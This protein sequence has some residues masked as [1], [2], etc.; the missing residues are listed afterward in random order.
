MMISSKFDSFLF[1]QILGGIFWILFS[2]VNFIDGVGVLCFV[3]FDG[4]VW[5]SSEVCFSVVRYMCLLT[6][7]AKDLPWV[8]NDIRKF[9]IFIP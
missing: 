8:I 5:I 2:Q 9:W 3:D 7:S 1:W 6:P 4:K